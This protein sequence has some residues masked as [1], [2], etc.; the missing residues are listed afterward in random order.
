MSNKNK[1]YL[2]LVHFIGTIL[3][4]GVEEGGERLVSFPMEWWISF[5]LR[6]FRRFRSIQKFYGDN[7]ISG[8]WSLGARARRLSDHHQQRQADSCMKTPRRRH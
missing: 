7:Y 4:G 1:I 8:H 6:G 3:A 2:P 5:H